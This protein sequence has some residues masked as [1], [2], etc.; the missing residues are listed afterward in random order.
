MFVRTYV[1]TNQEPYFRRNSLMSSVASRRL[2]CRAFCSVLVLAT[3][4]WISCSSRM[5]LLGLA[6]RPE[7]RGGP[8]MLLSG[9]MS[10]ARSESS[11]EADGAKVVCPLVARPPRPRRVPVPRGRPGARRVV[12]WDVCELNP[13]AI[14]CS[15]KG[16][17][18]AGV[19]LFAETFDT[20]GE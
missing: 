19:Q 11:S 17:Q 9:S 1:K 2:I 12:A 18:T 14:S 10:V 15:G 7:R 20:I 4:R 6:V 8:E 3:S 16:R 13:S 5:V